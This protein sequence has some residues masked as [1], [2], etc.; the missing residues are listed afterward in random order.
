MK[1][2]LKVSGF[3]QVKGTPGCNI[4]CPDEKGTESPK[5]NHWKCLAVI[6]TFLAPMKRGLK[7]Q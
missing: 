6:V 3:G 4:P 7:E 5:M 2:G 1:R